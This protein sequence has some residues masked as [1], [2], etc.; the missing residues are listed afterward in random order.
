MKGTVTRRWKVTEEGDP[1]DC[2]HKH[3]RDVLWVDER[4]D[5]Q[6]CSRC[7]ARRVRAKTWTFQHE[8]I[9]NGKRSYV[10]GTR[11]LKEDAQATLTE[12]LALHAKGEQL[13]PSKDTVAKFL[14]GWLDEKKLAVKPGTWRSYH[15][16]VE[17][18]LTPHLGDEKLSALAPPAISRC[19]TEL[20]AKGRRD[21]TGGLSPTSLEHTHRTLR[22]A[23]QAAVEDRLIARNPADALKKDAKPRRA[24]VEMRTWSAEQLGA[25]LDSTREQ[26]LHELFLVAATTACRRGELLGLRWEDIDLATSRL[27]VRRSR[28]SVAY[29]VVEDTPKTRKGVRTVDLD[30]ET[31]AAMRRWQLRQRKTERTRGVRAGPTRALYSRERTGPGCIRTRSPTRSTPRSVA[32][33]NRRSAFTIC[34]TP[35]PHSHC[36]PGCRP[37]S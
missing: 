13:D 33:V 26:R 19:Y 9:R 22:L 11:K 28:T 7:G 4:K 14:R 35:G 27:S 5:E 8:V 1:K 29:E 20:R 17:H 12:S 25:F 23:L 3:G 32:R 15:D 31:V 37:R 21:G 30:P 34:A 2:K 36:G 6:W 24:H 16:I 10:T 18:R